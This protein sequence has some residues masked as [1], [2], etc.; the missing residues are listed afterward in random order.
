MA[1]PD[2]EFKHLEKLWYGKLKEEGFDD[3]ECT[4]HSKR[5]LKEWDF[6]FF[7]NTFNPLKYESTLSYYS[8]AR[9]FLVH[10]NILILIGVIVPSPFKSAIQRKVWEL[11]C[12]GYS[13]REI[14]EK[15]GVFKK[16]TIHTLVKEL[17]QLIKK[18]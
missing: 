9:E 14:A 5:L 12:E 17:D 18:D 13:E 10:E 16:S 8:Q 11:H 7:R 2:E 15:I 6:N 1:Q 3:I 4:H